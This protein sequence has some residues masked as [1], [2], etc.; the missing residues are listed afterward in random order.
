MPYLSLDHKKSSSKHICIY[1]KK[2]VSLGHLFKFTK[3]HFLLK[4]YPVLR[5]FSSPNYVIAFKRNRNDN[6]MPVHPPASKIQYF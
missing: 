2:I 3:N 4:S 1:N 6:A 5:N